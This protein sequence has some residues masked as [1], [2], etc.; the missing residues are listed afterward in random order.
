[1]AGMGVTVDG[2]SVARWP[3]DPFPR[4]GRQRLCLANRGLLGP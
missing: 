1:M 4:E 3:L 2:D